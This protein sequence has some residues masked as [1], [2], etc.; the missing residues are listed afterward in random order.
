M[1]QIV[2]RMLSAIRGLVT[3]MT[4]TVQTIPFN[5]VPIIGGERE[6]VKDPML[7]STWIL[8]A[9]KLISGPISAVP[10]CFCDRATEQEYTD[11]SLLEYWESPAVGMDAIDVTEAYVGWLKMAG[12]FF[13]ILDD[14][15]L[16]PFPAAR[17]S[18]PK[19]IIARPDKMREVVTQ[20]KLTGWLWTDGSG[21]T[22]SLL[23][24]QVIQSKYWNP[25]SEFRGLPEY[26]AAK[27][28]V[29]TDYLNQKFA[30][31]LAASNG[32]TGPI[33]S[34]K[35]HGLSD[36]QV[37]QIIAQLEAKRRA[38]ARGDFVPAFLNGEITI[39][40]AS[41]RAPDA[42][43]QTQR[44]ADKEQIF[45]AFGI[46]PSM[47]TPQ[48]SYSIGSASDYYRLIETECMPTAKKL[49]ALISAITRRMTGL[50]LR[51]VHEWDE[52][53]VMQQARAERLS[54]ARDLWDR[55]MSWLHINEYLSLGM[56]PFPSWDTGYVSFGLTH[57]SALV[58]IETDVDYAEA[59]AAETEDEEPMED[60]IEDVKSAIRKRHYSQ[61]IGFA[62]EDS[63]TDDRPCCDTSCGCSTDDRSIEIRAGDGNR[64]AE[65][66][67]HMAKRRK[68]MAAFQSKFRKL[69]FEI[70]S[71]MLTK[72]KM[73]NNKSATT[74][75]AA[76]DFIFD[77][78]KFT[79]KLIVSMRN[80]S[81][82]ALQEAGDQLYS[83]I[84]KDDPWHMPMPQA[85]KFLEQRKNEMVGVSQQIFDRVRTQIDEGITA[86]DSTKE[87]ADRVRSVSNEISEGRSKVVAQ[88]ETAVAYGVGRQAA[89]KS[90]GV[91]FKRWLSSR[92]ISVRPTHTKADSDYWDNPIPI[93]E[94]FIVGGARLMHPGDPS[95]PPQEVI[96][97]H[98]VQTAVAAPEDKE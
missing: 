74:R 97:C 69:I 29:E 67:T 5:W 93:D 77:F 79:N 75:A 98:C 52:H 1:I 78:S 51:A 34:A 59:L 47:A 8:R 24:E 44:T 91:E 10:L 41:V 58:D 16:V 94:P 42:M 81:A 85:Q 82:A 27:L 87:I 71:E 33:V 23:P 84:A 83:E 37:K 19:L 13:A 50:N 4:E 70:R 73:Q 92:N 62:G 25:Y 9:I 90:A 39:Q 64:L 60:M 48:A 46:P 65:W 63:R 12:E 14:S 35:G 49:A 76:A 22:H 2:N 45:T 32:D 3:R 53:T 6:A 43:F 40:D 31:N 57:T 66:K 80:I 96:N 15:W 30:K 28:A 54:I 61:L 95:G 56:K 72:I 26:D 11:Q 17:S 55:G 86:G 7:Q 36:T 21:S 88:T 20:G 89:M 68:V 38:Q 18:F